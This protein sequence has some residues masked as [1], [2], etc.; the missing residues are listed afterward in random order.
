MAWNQQVASRVAAV[1]HDETAVEA[2]YSLAVV[3]CSLCIRG[4]AKANSKSD[5][6]LSEEKSVRRQNH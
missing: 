5:S 3:K 1:L 6:E 4:E 2:C